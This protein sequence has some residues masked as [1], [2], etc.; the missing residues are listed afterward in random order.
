MLQYIS[1]AQLKSKPKRDSFTLFYSASI[2]DLIHLRTPSLTLITSNLFLYQTQEP[3]TSGSPLINDSNAI[4]IQTNGLDFLTLWYQ[5]NLSGDLGP[6]L[7]G[8]PS[9]LCARSCRACCSWPFSH[10]GRCSSRACS[11]LCIA[12]LGTPCRGNSAADA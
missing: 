4:E 10:L 9:H 8:W 11:T 7:R 12:G 3:S 6:N 2:L 1:I 5:K